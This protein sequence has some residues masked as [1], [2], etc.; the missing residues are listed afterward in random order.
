M[1]LTEILFVYFKE[2][3][4]MSNYEMRIKRNIYDTKEKRFKLSFTVQELTTFI[5]NDQLENG[6]VLAHVLV[7]MIEGFEEDPELILK[8]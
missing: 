4:L 5:S 6:N 8:L 3:F 2:N 7:N 1:Y